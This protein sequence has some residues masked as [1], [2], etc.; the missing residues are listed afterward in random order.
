MVA[1]HQDASLTVFLRLDSAAACD[2]SHRVQVALLEEQKH[3]FETELSALK[4][5]LVSLQSFA[6]DLTVQLCAAQA[7]MW[8]SHI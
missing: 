7:A 4:S 5:Q 1:D 8:G 2:E 6:C 3:G